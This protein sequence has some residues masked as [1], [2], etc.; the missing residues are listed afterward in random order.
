MRW[1]VI[2]KDEKGPEMHVLKNGNLS[3]YGTPHKFLAKDVAQEAARAWAE[4]NSNCRLTNKK[5][6]VRGVP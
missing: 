5:M 1:V 6:V 4:V 2:Q 3:F